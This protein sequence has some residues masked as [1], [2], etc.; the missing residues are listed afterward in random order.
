MLVKLLE[1]M[2]WLQIAPDGLVIYTRLFMTPGDVDSY[3]MRVAEGVA[4]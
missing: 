3:I 4:S 1:Y 2:G